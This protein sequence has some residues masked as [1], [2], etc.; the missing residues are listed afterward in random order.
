M[1]ASFA[2][3]LSAIMLLWMSE[4]NAQIAMASQAI[5]S[6]QLVKLCGAGPATPAQAR[7][8]GFIVGVLQTQPAEGDGSEKHDASCWLRGLEPLNWSD[9]EL[10]DLVLAYADTFE[11]KRADVEARKEYLSTEPPVYGAE[12]LVIE[13]FNQVPKCN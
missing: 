12:A 7:C 6:R 11:K 5:G 13:A 8:I 9:K 4:A 2:A 1:K 10:I 3:L